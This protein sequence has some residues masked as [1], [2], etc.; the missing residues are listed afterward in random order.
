[1]P[2]A[3]DDI[4]MRALAGSLAERYQRA[5]DVLHDILNVRRELSKKGTIGWA[6]AISSPA[7]PAPAPDYHAPV[8]PGAAAGHDHVVSERLPLRMPRKIT[9]ARIR[10]REVTATR[11]CWN[12]RKPLPAK[13]AR[14]P[15]C[16]ENQ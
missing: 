16:D 11:F 10:T 9:P 3:V 6:G 8:A 5:E 1:V 2:I 14:C 12:C 13:A 7:S 15:F 4:V